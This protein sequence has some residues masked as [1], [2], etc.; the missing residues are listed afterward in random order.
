M[1]YFLRGVDGVKSSQLLKEPKEKALK[2]L[3]FGPILHLV[4]HGKKKGKRLMM[5]SFITGVKNT[6]QMFQMA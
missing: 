4:K 6:K 1:N 5:K 2:H 3:K